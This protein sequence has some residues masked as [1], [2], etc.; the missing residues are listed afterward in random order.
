MPV[1]RVEQPTPFPEV[2]ER[3]EPR[4]PAGAALR[5]EGVAHDRVI[6]LAVEAGEG[7]LRSEGH[8]L[9]R[10]GPGNLPEEL[11]RAAPRAAR[12]LAVEH[13]RAGEIERDAVL[14]E[15]LEDRA[16]AVVAL[17]VVDPS[18]CG[19]GEELK[20]LLSHKL[21]ASFRSSIGCTAQGVRAR[22]LRKREARR[23]PPPPLAHQARRRGTGC[24]TTSAPQEASPARRLRC[25]AMPRSEAHAAIMPPRAQ[26]ITGRGR[27]RVTT[28]LSVA[29]RA[30]RSHPLTMSITPRYASN[31][32]LHAASTR[33]PWVM[34]SPQYHERKNFPYGLIQLPF[35]SVK[36]P[37]SCGLPL[38]P[39][40][41]CGPLLPHSG[42]P[43]ASA[44]AFSF[45][46]MNLSYIW[47]SPV[48]GNRHVPANCGSLCDCTRAGDGGNQNQVNILVR[49][50]EKV[51]IT[52][53]CGSEG[54]G[55]SS[56]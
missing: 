19:G 9:L 7:V 4:R 37:V 55:D 39:P 49:K 52:T 18:D 43:T 36:K 6:R 33:S 20:R 14:A 27:D 46:S 40:A 56:C 13:L 17:A 26:A 5:R 50:D 22:T 1:G 34:S 25:C 24:C 41:S 48:P 35:C 45:S 51:S 2:R 29:M 10:G 31:G 42:L 44:A 54:S 32:P 23:R 53:V 47:N 38:Y 12:L 16:V 3:D 30:V 28:P 21:A 8:P 11:L 15:H